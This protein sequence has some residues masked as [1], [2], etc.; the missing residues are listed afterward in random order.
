MLAFFLA[1]T[2][3]AQTVSQ[4]DAENYVALEN[5]GDAKVTYYASNDTYSMNE[6]GKVSAQIQSF[7]ENGS[8]S[9]QG[10]LIDGM[11][12]GTWKKFDNEGN[13]TTEGTYHMGQKDGAWK[14]WDQDTLRVEMNYDKGKRIGLWKMYD[15]EGNLTAE[16]NYNE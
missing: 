16:K 5:S 12:H 3:S 14:V 15:S 4:F 11:K 13:V 6:A 9:E 8:L 7:H 10:M 1:G 2:L